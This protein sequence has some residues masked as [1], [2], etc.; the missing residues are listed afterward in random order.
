MS[1]GNGFQHELLHVLHMPGS[2]RISISHAVKQ[3]LVMS[4]A[5]SLGG[6]P[7]SKLPL[8]T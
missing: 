6:A 8:C 5:S 3:H 1:A 7:Y 4:C 2:F